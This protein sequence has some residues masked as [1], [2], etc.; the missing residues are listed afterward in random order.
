M[1]AVLLMDLTGITLLLIAAFSPQETKT[2]WISM[3]SALGLLS[4][5]PLYLYLDFP[6]EFRVV[7]VKKEEKTTYRMQQKGFLKWS[8]MKDID[9]KNVEFD[10]MNEAKKF[11]IRKYEELDKDGAQETKKTEEEVVL[12]KKNI[13]DDFRQDEEKKEETPHLDKTKQTAKEENNQGEEDKTNEH[14]NK[15]TSP[16][17]NIGEVT[18]SLKQLGE[19]WKNK[20]QESKNDEEEEEEEDVESQFLDALSANEEY[21]NNE[22]TKKMNEVTDNKGAD[23]EKRPK[24][25]DDG[26]KVDEKKTPTIPPPLTRQKSSFPQMDMDNRGAHGRGLLSLRKSNRYPPERQLGGDMNDHVTTD[27]GRTREEVNEP[28]TIEDIQNEVNVDEEGNY[29][30]G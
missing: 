23:T 8:D 7:R 12:N 14:Q 16:V 11:M 3:G 21:D 6:R 15:Y 26:D 9:K 4:L 20:Q 5:W 13:H 18:S 30:V 27:S 19:K 28:P 2:A 29:S 1:Y 24:G 25:A 10:D 22:T 17:K